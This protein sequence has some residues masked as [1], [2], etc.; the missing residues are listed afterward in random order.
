MPAL[1]HTPKDPRA[2]RGYVE[3]VR[4]LN[5]YFESND[6]EQLE[7][8]ERQLTQSVEW[9][10]GFLPA[11]YYKSVVL[12][13]ARKSDGAIQLLEQLLARDAP[14][15]AEILYNLSFA[16]AKKYKYESVSKA[17]VLAQRAEEF[18]E[19]DKRADLILL[20]SAMRAWIFAVFGGRDLRHE[21]DFE[22]RQREYLPRSIKLAESVVRD[23]RLHRLPDQTRAAVLVEA[24]NAAGV[25]Y[26]RIC[27]FPS[28][29]LEQKDPWS[30]ASRHFLAALAV[31]PR[32]VRVLDNLTTLNLIQASK[33]IR[34]EDFEEARRLELE[35]RDRAREAISY[36]PHDRF[37]HYRLAQAE[38]LL[39]NLEAARTA[40]ES[41]LS[42]PGEVS[43]EK[44]RRFFDVR[45]TSDIVFIIEQYPTE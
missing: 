20:S 22:K 21:A 29:F 39:G 1:D 28:R 41:A 36:N 34:R 8:A 43:D 3:G 40:A 14:F 44:L 32:D 18:A 6:G 23:K 37:R 45:D 12:A 24:H 42:E 16:Y 5:N 38:Y 30:A 9:D 10:P 25:G 17:I 15:K 35:T 31:H 26:M 11:Q 2:F 19:R 13:H 27:Q 4:R 33:A 7:E